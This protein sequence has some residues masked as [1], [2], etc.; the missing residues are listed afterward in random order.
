M[1]NKDSHIFVTDTLVVDECTDDVDDVVFA[2]GGK[3]PV[4]PEVD[5]ILIRGS[6]FLDLEGY[7]KAKFPFDCVGGIL[8]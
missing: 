7:L 8:N 6:V 4:V 5:R 3:G 1:E 2:D